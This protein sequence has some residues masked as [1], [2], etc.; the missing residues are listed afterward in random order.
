MCE[1]FLRQ[2]NHGDYVLVIAYQL[3]LDIQ[4]KQV[5]VIGNFSFITYAVYLYLS[6]ETLMSETVEKLSYYVAKN[7]IFVKK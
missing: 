7:S 2:C 5:L 1:Y 4:C 3:L 6:L